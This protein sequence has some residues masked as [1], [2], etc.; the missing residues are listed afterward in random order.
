LASSTLFVVIGTGSG[1]TLCD[2]AALARARPDHKGLMMAALPWFE[3][4][5]VPERV[6]A[7]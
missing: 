1:T 3:K 7:A 5:T 6:A 4:M 2:S